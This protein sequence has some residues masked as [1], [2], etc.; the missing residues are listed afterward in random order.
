MSLAERSKQRQQW[1]LTAPPAQRLS[2]S[3]ANSPLQ[4]LTTRN[5]QVCSAVV[6]LEVPP[7]CTLVRLCVMLARMVHFGLRNVVVLRTIF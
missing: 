5:L 2:R 1:G 4:A 3:A 7:A 6:L